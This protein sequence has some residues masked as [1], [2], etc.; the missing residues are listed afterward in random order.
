MRIFGSTALVL[1]TIALAA[2]G[3]SSDDSTSDAPT[4]AAKP[5]Q[6]GGSGASIDGETIFSA[7]CASCHTLAAAGA[8]GVVGPNLDEVKPDMQTVMSQVQ[9]GGGGMPSFAGTLSPAEITAVSKYV[10]TNAGQ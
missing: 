3:G 10:S 2:C 9:N 1:T 5:D 4:P 6:A 7:N 8:V